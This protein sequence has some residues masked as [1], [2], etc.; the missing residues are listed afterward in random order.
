MDDSQ[1]VTEANMTSSIPKGFDEKGIHDLFCECLNEL[2]KS[3]N[4]TLTPNLKKRIQRNDLLCTIP[5]LIFGMIPKMIVNEHDCIAPICSIVC[6]GCVPFTPNRLFPASLP[7]MSGDRVAVL[8]KSWYKTDSSVLVL[9]QDAKDAR[10]QFSGGIDEWPVSS[11]CHVENHVV[12]KR[13]AHCFN[14]FKWENSSF[15]NVKVVSWTAARRGAP[16]SEEDAD[17]VSTSNNESPFKSFCRSLEPAFSRLDVFTFSTERFRSRLTEGQVA[18][19]KALTND[20]SS[21]EWVLVD[22]V[23][24]NTQ[25]KP[26]LM[27]LTNPR[28]CLRKRSMPNFLAYLNAN[29]VHL[30][31]P[32]YEQEL[33]ALGLTSVEPITEVDY[34]EFQMLAMVAVMI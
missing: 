8:L 20:L 18:R 31:T 3:G 10:G 21:F 12:I 33:F 4:L 25:R 13:T 23:L 26:Y 5:A 29:L 34:D 16:E 7:W 24:D 11:V 17:G 30:Q 27:F 14:G 2:R 9:S 6:V 22:I 15:P 1:P 28:E 19:H 32:E